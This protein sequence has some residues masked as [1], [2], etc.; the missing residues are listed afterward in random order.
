MTGVAA[1]AAGVMAVTLVG[2]ANQLALPPFKTQAT[3]QAVVNE[4]ID[5]LNACDW[6]RLMAQYPANVEI[7]L[8]NGEVVG[9]R[10]AVGDLFRGFV[11]PRADG[12]LCG[13]TFVPEHTFT[14]GDTVNVKWRANAP[15]LAEP[16]FGADAYVTSGG[17][18]V[19]QVTTFDGA[20]LKFKP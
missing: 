4:H 15:F 9:G 3:P 6:N 19:A 11:R 2:V 7:F 5:A 8:P 14:V 16:Y 17:L 13:L 1:A 10:A 12:G 18:M 20:A